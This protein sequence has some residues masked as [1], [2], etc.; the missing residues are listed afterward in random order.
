MRT[1]EQGRAYFAVKCI[2]APRRLK[3]SLSVILSASVMCAAIS[4]A[5]TCGKRADCSDDNSSETLPLGSHSATAGIGPG[6]V[7][8]ADP[9]DAANRS[10]ESVETVALAKRSRL[11][12]PDSNSE[13]YYRNKLEVSLDVGWLPINIPFPFNVF[14][15]DPYDLYPLRYTLVPVMASVRWHLGSPWGPPVIRGNWDITFS[16][17]ATAIPKGAE[18]HYFSYDMGLRRNFIPRNWRI[19]PYWDV[20]AG[21]GYIN[22]KGPLGVYYAQGQNF[23]FN[24]NMGAGARYNLSPRYAVSAGLNW[25]HIS[26]ANRSSPGYSN[27]GINVYGPMIGLDIGLRPRSRQSQ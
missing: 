13:I 17:S 20:R 25:M 22:A 18:T 12:A 16:A 19:T 8:G 6:A 23:T 15:G 24:I 11:P 10:R 2:C 1:P 14:E 26:N 9:T 21:L 27:Y 5:Q 3:I 7:N 4:E